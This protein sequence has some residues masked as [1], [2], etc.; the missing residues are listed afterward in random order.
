MKKYQLPVCAAFVAVCFFAC[1]K[2]N[3]HI[4]SDGSYSGGRNSI[5]SL[6]VNS[7]SGVKV[8]GSPVA[9]AKIYKLIK[10]YDKGD[11]FEASG[12]QFVDG[13]FYVACD[14][15]YQIVK[16]KQSLPENS[17]ENSL[18]GSG[19]GDSNFE[20]ITYDNNNTPNFFVVEESVANGNQYQPRI[21]EYNG[22]MVYQKSIWADY[23]FTSANKNKA[24]EGIAWVFRGGEDYILG[25]VEGTG[26]IP[27]LKKTSSLWQKVAEITLPSSVSFT[28]YSDITVSG[29]KIAVTSQQDSRL[30]IGTLS[31]TDWSVTGGTIYE[32]PR[33][34]SSGVVGAGNSVLYAN[35][36]GVSFINDKQIVVVSDKA[37]SDQPAEQSYKDQS[38][39]IFNLPL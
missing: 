7:T 20:G 33:G 22:S 10:G 21:R 25:L 36:E 11:K 14:N 31:S 26:K 23:Y 12:V 29:N 16:I 32:F 15:S 13:Y 19:S 4:N 24:F 2:A 3:D 17:N 38:I 18:L 39:H 8:L 35:I 28:D 5:A 34:N 1:N 37:K 27:V 9:E 6:N 30:W